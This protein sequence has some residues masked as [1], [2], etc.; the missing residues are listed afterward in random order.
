MIEKVNQK[1]LIRD[2]ESVVA[3]LRKMK[4]YDINYSVEMKGEDFMVRCYNMDLGQLNIMSSFKKLVK[5][6]SW[7]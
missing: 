7:Y 2:S 3:V 1:Y 6:I 4:E 5:K